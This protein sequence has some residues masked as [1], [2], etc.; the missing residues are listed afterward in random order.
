MSQLVAT[1]VLV[2]TIAL[3]LRARNRICQRSWRIESSK[4][5]PIGES[6]KLSSRTNTRRQATGIITN[7]GSG[8]SRVSP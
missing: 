4:A 2:A 5:L 7:Y 8:R 3:H 1:L 6:I